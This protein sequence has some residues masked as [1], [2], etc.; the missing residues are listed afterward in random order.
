MRERGNNTFTYNGKSSE[1]FGLH[2]DTPSTASAPKL[3]YEAINIPFRSH[4]IIDSSCCYENVDVKYKTWMRVPNEYDR[5]K[6]TRNLKSWLMSEPEKYKMLYDS[7][8]GEFCRFATY[9]DGLNIDIAAND[10]LESELIFSA[11]PYLY[12]ISSLEYRPCNNG[13]ILSNPFDFPARPK[14]K[15]LANG[16]PSISL[17]DAQWKLWNVKNNVEIDCETMVVL[18]DGQ[19]ITLIDRELKDF[20]LQKGNTK[21]TWDS[22]I[23]KVWIAPCWRCL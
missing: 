18:Q 15:M 22:T 19:E 6:V 16:N 4:A 13:E 5:G 9:V 7:Y 14:I 23:S 3:I 12:K 20:F 2:I 17:G 11:D 8:D 1:L 10:V 21:I